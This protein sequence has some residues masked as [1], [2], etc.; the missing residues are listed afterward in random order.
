MEKKEEHDK[1]MDATLK[2]IDQAQESLKETKNT[3]GTIDKLYERLE[4]V[5]S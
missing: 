3:I 5:L 4:Q 2:R 1:S